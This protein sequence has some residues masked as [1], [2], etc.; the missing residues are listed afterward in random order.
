MTEFVGFRA[1]AEYLGLKEDSLRSSVSLG[2]GP[3]PEMDLVFVPRRV[4]QPVFTKDELD[5]WAA[6]RPARRKR[7]DRTTRPTTEDRPMAFGRK[8]RP[9]PVKKTPDPRAELVRAMAD[10]GEIVASA[11]GAC[12]ATVRAD[13]PEAVQD[14]RQVGNW[15]HARRTRGWRYHGTC[16]RARGGAALLALALD[17]HARPVRVTQAH[18]DVAQRLGVPLA[19]RELEKAASTDAGRGRSPFRHIPGAELTELRA[20]VEKRH[21]ELTV[22]VV[23]VSGWPCAVCGRSHELSD[24]WGTYQ[25]R[26][27]CA[28]CSGLIGRARIPGNERLE[29]YAWRAALEVARDR[30]PA[31][32][33]A[34]FQLAREVPGYRRH[35][36]EMSTPREPWSY[37]A[38][39]PERQPTDLERLAELERRLTGAAA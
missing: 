35:D 27:V 24:A 39:L 38:D 6:E 12:G 18:H 32:G 3:E 4:P 14:V 33:V 25:D 17:F 20:A 10:A 37:V 13:D 23:H 29:T 36:S 21:Q 2:A 15:P 1:A 19:Y 9:A 31:R 28:A 7:T 11:C 26:P 30:F 22:P 34:R 8:T 16:S 5:G